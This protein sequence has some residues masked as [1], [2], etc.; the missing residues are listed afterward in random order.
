[1]TGEHPALFHYAAAADDLRQREI[2][3]IKA[4]T[5]PTL[6]GLRSLGS[7]ELRR[8]VAA[9][10]ERLGYV[11][12]ATG[13]TGDLI[14]SKDDRKLVVACA[15]PPEPIRPQAI[16][17]LHEAILRTAAAAGFYVTARHFEPD[18]IGYAA[19]LPITLVEGDKLVAS[20]RRSKAGIDPPDAYKAMCKLC[21]AVVEH[22]LNS[23]RS[24]ALRQRPFCCSDNRARRDLPRM[25]QAA[26]CQRERV[27]RTAPGPA[28]D[29]QSL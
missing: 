9:M 27:A 5:I 10:L 4:A 16:A 11:H 26:G 25:R 20:M 17:C 23:R 14:V 21:G 18:A 6:A 19:G 3:R 28:H 1:M 24:R 22:R 7:D 8:E 13:D 12:H 2:E 29:R 15:K